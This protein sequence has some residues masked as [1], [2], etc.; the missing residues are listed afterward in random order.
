M[1]PLV[2]FGATVRRSNQLSYSH[3]VGAKTVRRQDAKVVETNRA[4]ARM[5]AQ[6]EFRD[7]L[8]GGDRRSIADSQRVRAWALDSL[9]TVSER[10]AKLLRPE[11]RCPRS[12]RE[13]LHL[14]RPFRRRAYAWRRARFR[15]SRST[16]RR[17]LYAFDE[18]GRPRSQP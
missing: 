8:S 14:V 11:A 16:G 7:L 12:R 2:C 17:R 3:H 1:L 4:K 6:T 10:K 9:A 5:K 13:I 15:P 18:N